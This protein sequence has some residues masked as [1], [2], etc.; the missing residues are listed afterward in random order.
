MSVAGAEI[1]SAAGT[2]ATVA[3]AIVAATTGT[4]ATVA[5]TIVTAAAGTVA[6][7]ITGT[8]FVAAAGTVAAVAGTIF[9]AAAGTVAAVAGTRCIARAR[10]ALS[11][12]TATSG[13][14]TGFNAGRS[15]ATS[16]SPALSLDN[17]HSQQTSHQSH[18]Q[19]NKHFFHDFNIFER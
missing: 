16:T 17:G 14:L 4:V 11:G 3:G 6:A 19:T 1:V 10:I 18:K 12:V 13:T 8:I 7:T 2:V 15:T 9:V 5:G